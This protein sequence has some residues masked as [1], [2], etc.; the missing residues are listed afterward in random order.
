MGV[1]S[2][3]RVKTSDI[4]HSPRSERKWKEMWTT[5]APAWLATRTWNAVVLWL[6]SFPQSPFHKLFCLPFYRVVHLRCC[7]CHSNHCWPSANHMCMVEEVVDSFSHKHATC[8]VENEHSHTHKHTRT[9]FAKGYTQTKHKQNTQTVKQLTSTWRMMRGGWEH[10]KKTESSKLK[11]SCEHL[12]HTHQRSTAQYWNFRRVARAHK[13]RK[14]TNKNTCP[15]Q[16]LIFVYKY[17]KRCYFI[18]KEIYLAAWHTVRIFESN[19]NK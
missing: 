9:R 1:F 4:R 14:N 5:N 16:K 17:L 18:L 6:L 7:S 2:F 11:C 12:E 8:F 13:N 10:V 3:S 19:L 15:V